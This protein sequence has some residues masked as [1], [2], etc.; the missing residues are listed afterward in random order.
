MKARR[1]VLDKY[2]SGTGLNNR[3]KNVRPP[4]RF[5]KSMNV[6]S[7]P[8]ST[9]V[10]YVT[11]AG[12][13]LISPRPTYRAPWPSQLLDL[14]QDLESEATLAI[15]LDEDALAVR[16]HLQLPPNAALVRFAVPIADSETRY[17]IGSK[18]TFKANAS[19][20]GM[21]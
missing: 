18:P 20:N 4:K 8:Y 6:P 14:L 16:N 5:T 3:K 12:P 19:P 9:I 13:R 11:R 1:M 21:C 15:P 2:Y 7:K 17:Y 10:P